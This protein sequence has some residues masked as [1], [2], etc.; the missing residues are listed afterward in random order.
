MVGHAGGG[1]RVRLDEAEALELMTGVAAR[2][3]MSSGDCEIVARHLV[4][5]ELRGAVGM[6]R[7]II[8]ADEVAQNGPY[9][10]EPITVTRESDITAVVDGGGNY[11]LVVAEWATR[12]AISKAERSGL[13]VVSA[14]NHRYSGTLGYY[15]E[16]VARRGLIGISI[17]SGSFGSVAPYGARE[18]RLDTNPIAV[19][20]P[21]TAEPIIW[22]IATSAISGSEVYRRLVTGEELPKGVALDPHGAPTQDPEEALAGTILP[23]GGHRGSGL[24]MVIRLLGLL[25]GIAPFPDK[26]REFAFLMIVINPSLFLPTDEFERRATEFAVGIRAAEPAPGFD[27]VRL[28]FDRSIQVRAQRRRHGI[29]IARAVYERLDSIRCSGAMPVQDGP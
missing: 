5:D 21:T 14:N 28:P 2:L 19:G 7:I 15:A 23:W 6:S 12:L 26:K 25:S 1:D 9:A 4:D 17:A 11:G 29:E 8:A 20:F 10:G 16:L 13:A 22:D 24:A 18:G 3:G 27:S